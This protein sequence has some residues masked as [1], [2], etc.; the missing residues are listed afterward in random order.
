MAKIF[1]DPR[2]KIGGSQ[3]LSPRVETAMQELLEGF[4]SECLPEIDLSR[5]P[6]EREEIGGIVLSGWI[7]VTANGTRFSYGESTTPAVK[8][9]PS[10]Q[11]DGE[12]VLVPRWDEWRSASG[13][14]SPEFDQVDSLPMVTVGRIKEKL[15]FWRHICLLSEGIE[16]TRVRIE[17]LTKE[18]DA[19]KSALNELLAQQ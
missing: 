18:L 14:G 15:L 19:E 7:L 5:H 8:W 9:M 13:G 6:L 16:L 4:Q 2:G 10:I 1:F 11:E 3:K 12:V 17:I